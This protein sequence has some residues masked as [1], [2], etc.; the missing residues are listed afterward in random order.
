MPN[1]NDQASGADSPLGLVCTIPAADRG[2]RLVS[3][4]RV[5][6]RAKSVGTLK[7]GIRLVFEGSDEVARLLLDLVLAERACCAQF[8]YSIVFGAPHRTIELRV[9]AAGSLVQQLRRLYRV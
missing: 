6:A 4:L 7:H 9:E 1:A 2:E 8:T 5:V 3:V